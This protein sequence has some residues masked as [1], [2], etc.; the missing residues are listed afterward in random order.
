MTTITRNNFRE[1]QAFVNNL[2]S[3]NSKN[4]K[5]EIIKSYKNH[6]FITKVLH[7]T[8]NPYF[9]FY[10]SS[11]NCKK[12][13]GLFK[14]NQYYDIFEPKAAISKAIDKDKN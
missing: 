10:V 14:Y 9:K 11:A 2:N 13:P 8:Y 5:I 1:L 3:T 12:N 6:E 4:D 7:Y